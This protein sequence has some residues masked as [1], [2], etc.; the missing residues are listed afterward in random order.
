MAILVAIYGTVLLRAVFVNS[1]A[2]VRR[3]VRQIEAER[4][5]R[6]DLLTHL[7]NRFAFNETL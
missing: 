1:L 6:Q 7:P 5:V 2:F 3:L 4:T